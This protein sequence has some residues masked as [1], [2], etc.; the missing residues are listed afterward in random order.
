MITTRFTD[1]ATLSIRDCW[2]D[3]WRRSCT[4]SAGLS[5][6]DVGT[7]TRQEPTGKAHADDVGVIADVGS[8]PDEDALIK[9]A[10]RMAT[11]IVEATGLAPL[12]DQTRDMLLLPP[13]PEAGSVDELEYVLRQLLQ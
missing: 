11:R 4:K 9:I 10:D 13:L 12:S 8:T 3:V 1:I 2:I 6:N 5:R 7:V